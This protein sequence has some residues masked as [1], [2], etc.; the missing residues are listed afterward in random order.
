MTGK[1]FGMFGGVGAAFGLIMGLGLAWACTPTSSIVLLP[2]TGPAGSKIT[3]AGQVAPDAGPA[4]PV[5]IRWNSVSGLLLGTVSPDASR[6][7]SAEVTVPEVGE[8]IYYVMAIS[9][10]AEAGRASFQVVQPEQPTTAAG[11]PAGSPRS[12]SA[13]VWSG[14]ERPNAGTSSPISAPPDAAPRNA[15]IFAGTALVAIG[16]S[17]LATHLILGCR[18][19]RK[20]VQTL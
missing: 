7:F 10:K 8:G 13:D 18:P 3:V 9:G 15:G 2:E 14:L 11:E 6:N 12:I 20:P 16:L 19:K 1:R 17:A 4:A 5:E